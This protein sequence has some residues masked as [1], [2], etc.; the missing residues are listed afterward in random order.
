[1]QR[2]NGVQLPKFTGKSGKVSATQW[3][4]LFIQWC[5]LHSF[6]EQQ[7]LGRIVFHLADMAQQW[8]LSLPETSRSTLQSLKSRLGKQSSFNLDVLD[9]KQQ[10]DETCEESP[11]FNRWHVMMKYQA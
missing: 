4:T 8:Y 9:I 2:D 11:E 5:S 6:S 7:I 10:I 1:M 3:W